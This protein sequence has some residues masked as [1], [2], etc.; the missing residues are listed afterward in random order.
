MKSACSRFL[1]VVFV[2]SSAQTV[3]AEDSAATDLLQESGC[4][5]CHAVA[6]EKVAPPF[7][8]IAAKYKGKPDAVDRLTKHITVANQV[9]V[10][11][12][13]EDHGLIKTQDAAK[14]RNLVEWIL[15]R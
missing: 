1:A 5:K 6:R 2:L 8:E 13:K 7:R 14:I 4:T 3:A 12:S 10:D 9:E 11:G 15:S